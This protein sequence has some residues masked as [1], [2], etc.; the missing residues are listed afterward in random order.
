MPGGPAEGIQEGI[1]GQRAD[2]EREPHAQGIGQEETDSRPHILLGA[3]KEEDGGENRPHAGSPSRGK[4]Q[5]YQV[6]TQESQRFALKVEFLFPLEKV[7]GKDTADEKAEEDDQD[8]P[9]D[10]DGIPVGG[11]ELPQIR[12]RSSQSDKESAES[13]PEHERMEKDGLSPLSFVIL[14]GEFFKREAGD[15]RQVRRDQ[16]QYAGRKEGKEPSSKGDV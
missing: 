11:Q 3:G 8:A 5:T 15:K 6:R 9:G 12:G 10:P 4:G 7:E 13:Q 16:G 2:Q 1:Q 14:P